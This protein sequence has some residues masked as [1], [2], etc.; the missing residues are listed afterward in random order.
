MAE[1]DNQVP[2]EQ[3]HTFHI[4]PEWKTPQAPHQ[5]PETWVWNGDEPMHPFSGPF[6]V[7]PHRKLRINSLT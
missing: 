3:T 2:L 7:C 6:D 4:M 1:R 5:P